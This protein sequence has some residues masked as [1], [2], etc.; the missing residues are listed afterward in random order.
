M[1]SPT[2]SNASPTEASREARS[3]FSVTPAEAP[4]C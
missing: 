3:V 1:T 4:L 2:S